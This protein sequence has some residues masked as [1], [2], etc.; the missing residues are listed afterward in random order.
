M[1]SEPTLDETDRKILSQISQDNDISYSELAERIGVSRN[2]VYR[3]V[4]ELTNQE[5]IDKNFISNTKVNILNSQRLG[6]SILL[7]AMKFD[8]Q[9]LEKA[10][11]FLEQRREVKLLLETYGKYDLIAVL[12]AEGGKEREIISNLRGD[13]KKEGPEV[14]YSNIYPSSLQKLDLTLR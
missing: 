3:R 13:M 10:L 12:F 7:F 8:I 2:T 14:R 9:D 4:K 6:I 1:C 5:I 11:K